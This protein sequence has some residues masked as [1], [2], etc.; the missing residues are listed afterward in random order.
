M[1]AWPFPCWIFIKQTEPLCC[2]SCSRRKFPLILVPGVT[3][4]FTFFVIRRR[5]NFK[6]SVP[7]NTIVSP[8]LKQYSC[9]SL[10]SIPT[11]SSLPCSSTSCPWSK[12]RDISGIAALVFVACCPTPVGGV[13]YLLLWK[14][15]R[16]YIFLDFMQSLLLSA[17]FLFIVHITIDG[18][19]VLKAFTWFN[20]SN[21]SHVVKFSV[22]IQ[23]CSL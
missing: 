18:D 2:I 11:F 20:A 8:A 17:N 7:L 19:L 3:L 16:V 9:T 4:S 13:P 14:S 12:R 6:L 22:R 21:K 10:F 15:L 1:L 23:L 5:L